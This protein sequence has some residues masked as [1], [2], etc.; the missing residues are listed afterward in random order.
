[1]TGSTLPPK[2]FVHSLGDRYFLGAA[3]ANPALGTR[4]RETWPLRFGSTVTGRW[5]SRALSS[6]SGTGDKLC[7]LK[8]HHTL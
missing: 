5:R 6:H 1:M 3:E 4:G 8:E 7:V 2:L